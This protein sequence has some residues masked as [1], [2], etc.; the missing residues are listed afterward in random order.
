MH[1]LTA[2]ISMCAGF[3]G[4]SFA[5]ER[6]L[7]LRQLHRFKQHDVPK[8]L[9]PFIQQDEFTKSQNY[10]HASWYGPD[11]LLHPRCIAIISW[12][13]WLMCCNVMRW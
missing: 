13:G 5:W 12:C 6:Y 3:L 7:E 10:G 4:I 9:Q 11:A 2:D 1:V 8:H